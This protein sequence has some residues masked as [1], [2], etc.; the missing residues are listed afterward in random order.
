MVRLKQIT[1]LTLNPALDL[2]LRVLRLN[3]DDSNRV[4]SVRKDPGGKGINVSRVLHELGRDVNTLTFLGGP[5]GMAFRRLMNQQ[6][7]P[8]HAVTLRSETRQNIIITETEG[9]AQTRLHQREAE[10]RPR[11]LERMRELIEK[12]AEKTDF[13]ALGGTLP[14]GV[15]ED[16]Y[17]K[18]ILHLRERKVK[19]ALDGDGESYRLGV[20]ALPFMIKPNQYELPRLVGRKIEDRRQMKAAIWELLERGIEAVVVSLGKEGALG[21]TGKEIWLARPPLVAT[22][23][24]VG[25]GDSLVAGFLLKW[26]EGASLRECLK[27]GVAAGTATALTPGTELLHA[28]DLPPILQKVRVERA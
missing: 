9:N 8:V 20:A 23:S 7:V 25:S 28:K 21:A 19:C 18:L 11:E 5:T 17:Q 14:P 22:G 24:T 13:L 12:Y 10:V 2:T 16:F 4:E 15:P 27:F 26:S 6:G 3:H 1:T